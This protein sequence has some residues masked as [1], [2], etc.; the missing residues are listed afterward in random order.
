MAQVKTGIKVTQA[1]GFGGAN[2]G[3][4]WQK[5]YQGKLEKEPWYLLTNFENLNEAIKAYK[6]RVGIEAMFK[7]CKTGGYN[8]EDTKASI[9]RLSRLVLLIAIAYTIS[10][11]TGKSIKACGQQKYVGRSRKIKQLITKNSN[12]L[13]GLYGNSWTIAEDFMRK[14]VEELMRLN[15]NKLRFYQKGLRAMTIIQQAL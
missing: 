15:P 14:L 12:F 13:L 2:I 7:D 3:A 4:Y 1:H 11:K 5:R 10:T 9:D 6:K 8:L